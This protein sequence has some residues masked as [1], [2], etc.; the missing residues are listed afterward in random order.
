[1]TLTRPE[2]I[3]DP[4][5]LVYNRLVLMLKDHAGFA[6]LVSVGNLINYGTGADADPEK[7]H[8]SEGDLPMVGILPT[9]SVPD[10][11]ADSSRTEIKESYQAVLVTGDKRVGRSLYP[12]RWEIMRA[13][14]V[15]SKQNIT[16]DWDGNPL[17]MLPLEY[18][19]T[20]QL[21]QTLND[22]TGWTAVI[23]FRVPISIATAALETS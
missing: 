11:V 2:R 21:M 1:M 22:I 15:L 20:S 13:F 4:L 17:T 5:T 14:S 19:D 9:T 12:V 3:I 18:L 6:D 10:I 16:L 23:A 7:D 8:V